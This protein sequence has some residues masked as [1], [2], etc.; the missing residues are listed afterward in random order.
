MSKPSPYQLNI[1]VQTE[2]LEEQS[3]INHGPYF[4]AYTIEIENIGTV[5]AQL[6]SRHWIISDA[7]E[8]T[9]EVQGAGVVGM[10][11]ILKPGER[12][13][14]TSGCPLPTPM[15]KMRGS[16]QFIS[17]DGEPFEVPIPEFTLAMPRTLH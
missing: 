4:F 16:Y 10:Q 7:F 9:Q 6:I 15:G 8:Q 14:Y 2:F 13:E 5:A 11:P 12:F 17:E 3:D 1:T